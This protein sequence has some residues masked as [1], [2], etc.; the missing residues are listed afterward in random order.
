MKQKIK[1]LL[2]KLYNI[3]LYPLSFLEEPYS[4]H[5]D[6]KG[7]LQF[8]D[9]YKNKRCFIVGNGPSLNKLDLD[10]LK[11]EFT[12]GVNSIFYMTE[13]NGF[14]PTFYMVEDNHVIYDNLTDINNYEVPYKFFPSQYKKVIKPSSNTFFFNMNRGF[15]EENSPNYCIPRFSKNCHERMYA[16]QSVTIMNIQLAF[17]MGFTQ[18]YL[19]GMDF[20]YKI[21]EKDEVTGH[22]ILST[23]DEDENH[24]DPRYFGAGKKWLDPKLENVLTS[25]QFSKIKF[26]RFNRKIYNATPGGKLNVFERVEF[27]SLFEKK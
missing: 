25:Y 10:L 20:D 11:D 26:E 17:Y 13:R 9:K 21:T 12:F 27:N 22:N 19:I 7:I 16:G 15:Y 2:Q 14:R 24:F 23:K 1:S 4:K 3:G 18:V 5:Y 6:K 8:K